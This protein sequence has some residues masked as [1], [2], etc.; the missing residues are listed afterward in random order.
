MRPN[1]D[2]PS[3]SPPGRI[4][5]A[6]RG[7]LSSICKSF[8]LYSDIVHDYFLVGLVVVLRELVVELGIDSYI[9]S[10]TVQHQFPR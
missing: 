2:F 7:Y 9:F 1:L 10:V 3:T 5:D 4:S 6:N 8:N